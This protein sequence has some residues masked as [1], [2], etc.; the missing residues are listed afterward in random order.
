M[1]VGEDRPII[2]SG[3]S[4]MAT[5]T[6]PPATEGGGRSITVKALEQEGPF[7]TIELSNTETGEVITKRADGTW[8]VTIK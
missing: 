2:V 4:T 3:G 8:T 6:L 7:K 5:I 1:A